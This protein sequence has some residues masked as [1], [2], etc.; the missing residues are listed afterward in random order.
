MTTVIMG[1]KEKGIRDHL[2]IIGKFDLESQEGF[3]EE[4]TCRLRLAV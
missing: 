2:R 1:R 4:V 3:L